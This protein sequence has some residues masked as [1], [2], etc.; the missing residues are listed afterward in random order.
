MQCVN[1]S[2]FISFFLCSNL[3]DYVIVVKC[4][5]GRLGSTERKLRRFW[6][7]N[8]GLQTPF[9]ISFSRFRSGGIS[10]P[11]LHFMLFFVS[12]LSHIF[13]VVIFDNLPD[14]EEWV[15]RRWIASFRLKHRSI[16]VRIPLFHFFQILV[17]SSDFKFSFSFMPYDFLF[18]SPD[19]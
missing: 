8:T 5:K 1:W 12:F 9:F 19:S 6:T 13:Y 4:T 7:E 14:L 18:I 15:S 10:D 3:I 16:N 17:I 2:D 11:L